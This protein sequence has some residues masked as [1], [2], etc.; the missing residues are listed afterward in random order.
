MLVEHVDPA[1]WF[2]GALVP[3]GGYR[4]TA[5]HLGIP[6]PDLVKRARTDFEAILLTEEI[7]LTAP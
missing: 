1:A 4:T 2:D 5:A 7:V 6:V 3:F